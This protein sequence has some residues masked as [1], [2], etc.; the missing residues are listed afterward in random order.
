MSFGAKEIIV[1]LIVGLILFGSSKIPE[2]AR[3]LRKGIEEF[4]K[5][6]EELSKGI[7]T[8]NDEQAKK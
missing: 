3:S 2:F 6:G 5:T 4:K 7:E 8:K 1:I